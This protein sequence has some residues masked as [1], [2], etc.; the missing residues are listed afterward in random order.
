MSYPETMTEYA[1]DTHDNSDAPKRLHAVIESMD[2]EARALFVMF[3]IDEV[4]CEEI[5]E[6][7]GVPLGTVYS[8][9][10]NQTDMVYRHGTQTVWITYGAS[11]S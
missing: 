7:L 8:R 2:L 10:Q 3:E 11:A 4:S 1:K 9:A 6:M 5:A